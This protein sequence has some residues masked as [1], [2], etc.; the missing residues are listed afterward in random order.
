MKNTVV[1]QSD[2][3]QAGASR[4][5]RLFLCRFDKPSL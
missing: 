2:V 4:Y 5:N 3:L 1:V